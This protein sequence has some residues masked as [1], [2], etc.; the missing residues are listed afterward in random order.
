MK[1]CLAV[2]AVLGL[3]VVGLGRSAS[4]AGA[5]SAA[6]PAPPLPPPAE[7]P[8]DFARDIK[9]IFEASC[10]KCH[11]H[12][13]KKGGFRLDSRELILEGGES[14]PGAKAGSSAESLLIQLVAGQDPDRLMPAKGA[15]LTAR[16]IGLLRVW[17]DQGLPW[18]EEVKL[19]RGAQA[20]LEPRRVELPP[21]ARGVTN[22]VDRLLAPYFAEHGF[23]PPEPVDDARFARR[24]YLDVTGLLPAPEDL[25]A[26]EQDRREDKRARLV[27]RLL[28]DD[29]GYAQHWM[30]FWND[31]LRNDYR[32][33]GYIDGGRKQI[34]PW[35]HAALVTNM[36]FDRFVA[37]LVNPDEH[38]EGFTK[39]IVWRGAVN[40]SQTPP[41]QA[42]QNVS[43]VF[44]G[45][46]L[47]C[48]SCHDS[49]ISDWK[50]ADAYGLASVYADE[51][52][53]LVRCD[54]PTGEKATRR[55]LFPQLGSLV[56]S[57][58]RAERLESLARTLT[59]PR[60]GRLTRTIVNRLWARFLGRG[61]IEPVDEMDDPPWHRDLLDWLAVD[62]AEHGYD[63][64]HTIAL[65]L[66]SSAYQ[67]PAVAGEEQASDKYVFRGPV[68]KRLSAEQ[69]ADALS[70]LTATWHTLPANLDLDF[71]LAG[72][73]AAP[74]ARWIWA[75]PGAEQGVAP[76]TIYLRR[77]LD[78]PE[79]P[80]Q[81]A[82]VVAVD[83]RFT[84][85][86]NG[87]AAGS[88]DQWERPRI[89][90]VRPHLVKGRNTLALAA[91]ND[92][93]KEKDPT[94]NPAGVY[95]LAWLSQAPAPV[96]EV[97]AP[98]SRSEPP[99]AN[100]TRWDLGSDAQWLCSTNKVDGWERPEFEA[101]GWTPAVELGGAGLAPWS[102]ERR[103]ATA[104]ATAGQYGRV[105]A[106]LANNDPLLTALG[107]PNREQVVTSRPT[108]AT[109]MQALELTNG[110]TLADRLK[111]GTANLL[112]HG[113]VPSEA[114]AQRLYT[115]GL[116]RGPTPDELKLAGEL[117]GDP[118][119]PEGLEDFLWAMTML[120]EFQLVY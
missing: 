68:V 60:N 106:V 6:T 76:Q 82:M 104:W 71:A 22:P 36:P 17:V 109:T 54:A 85:Y 75:S 64:K 59:D 58:N 42:A 100:P 79:V 26:F 20:P 34:T 50:L 23:R 24:A 77:T 101:T 72:A 102:L 73:P 93:A 98:L 63:L 11:A 52:L 84:L 96:S 39:G 81:A 67:L 107:R 112:E 110:A 10:I 114:L 51:P 3:G 88:G 47:K 44:L 29:E 33:T 113:P 69:Y 117:L 30:T 45:I 2:L 15:P 18:P 49:F 94:P 40:A 9:P 27:Q 14:G 46:N 105:R 91:T 1:A 37:R 95:V 111:R 108:P 87:H 35:L 62:L 120:P 43:Q 99:P 8:A 5:A 48:A 53:E 90:D 70:A 78:L 31:A 25:R 7:R 116:S 83:N 97:G 56:E 38:S 12:G 103:L 55:F 74:A 13:Q 41:L 28:A 21:S 61:L 4:A 80:D 32:G 57:T 65:I 66:T 92:A 86:V 19:G 115:H 16:Q 118:V 89:L 119:R